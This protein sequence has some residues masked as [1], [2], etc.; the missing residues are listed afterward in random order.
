MTAAAAVVA[1]LGVVVLLLLRSRTALLTGVILLTAGEIVLALSLVPRHDL[2]QATASPLRIAAL[3]VGALAI[4]GLAVVLVLRPGLVPVVMLAAAP[5]RVPVSLGDQDAFLLIPLYAVIA[6]AGLA[7]LV[8]AF[9]GEELRAPPLALAVPLGAYVLLASV[10]FLWTEDRDAGALELVFFLLPFSALAAIVARAP[11]ERWLPKA[12]AATIVG[13]GLLF[14]A[15]GLYQS[16]THTLFFAP[17]LE[18]ANAYTTFFRVTSLFKD[19][20][21]YGRHLVI[22]ISVLLV[23]ALRRRIPLRYAVPPI[24]FLWLGLY[25]SYSQSSMVALVVVATGL[26]LLLG[27]RRE[28]IVIVAAVVALVLVGTGTLIARTEGSPVQRIT[29][30]RSTLVT[31]S[32]RVFLR[33]PVAGVGIGAQPRASAAEPQRRGSRARAASHTTLLTVAAELGVIG[34]AVYISILAGAFVLLRAAYRRD[35]DMG[36][37]LAA[38][39]TTILVQ[40]LVY[41][42]FFEDPLTWESLALAS[43]YAAPRTRE[44]PREA[45]AHLARW[46]PTRTQALVGGALLLVLLGVV[47][48]A[49]VSKYDRPSAGG[50]VTDTTGFS[51]S[52]A[53]PTQPKPPPAKPPPAKPP[54]AAPVDMPCWKTFGGNPGRTLSRPTIRLGRPTKSVWARGM[55]D[56]MEFPPTYCAGRLYINLERGTTVAVEADTGKVLWRRKVLGETPSSPGIAGDRVIVATVGGQVVALRTRDGVPIWQVRTNS[57]LESSP[58]VVNGSVY[59]GAHDGRLFALDVRNGRVRWV[60]DTNGRINAS[61]SVVRDRVCI[62]TYAGTVTCLRTRDGGR[63]WSRYFARNAFQS[64]SFYASPSTDG[65]R[66]YAVARSG[67]ILAL[68]VR[69]GRTVWSLNT[70]TLTYATPAVA[71]GRIFVGDMSGNLRAFR[72]GTGAQLWRARVGGRILAP[73]LVVGGLVFFSTLNGHTYAAQTTSGRLVWSFPAGKYAP[74]I[75]TKSRYY[76]SLN[77]LLVAFNAEGTPGS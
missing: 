23:L 69:D 71:H 64:E 28:R 5:F 4:G 56:L 45:L 26:A 51:V 25:P 37:G 62:A 52:V 48:A 36:L 72:A 42:G 67:R 15:I 75:A 12:L 2:E 60:Y 46:R 58:V 1:G 43:L 22:A 24:V 77:G 68:S 55:R 9:R 27:D 11:L 34:L 70:F 66:L 7:L 35:P 21:L 8:R 47:A 14:A 73:A 16:A 3:V 54:R 53:R 65:A 29:S 17:T 61:P 38:A 30:G 10:S 57:R 39:F 76:L 18:V 33:K 19:P 44:A 50:L 13:L 74:G 63:I 6:A 59:L 49:A 40:S 31:D 32:T 41:S 20:S